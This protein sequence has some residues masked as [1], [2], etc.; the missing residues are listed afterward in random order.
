MRVNEAGLV[1]DGGLV[2]YQNQL[3]S[4]KRFVRAASARAERD[5]V[6]PFPLRGAVIVGLSLS[7]WL[8]LALLV[9]ALI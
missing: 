5:D 8:S 2:L 4:H 3:S 1:N 6:Y 9:S 7:L